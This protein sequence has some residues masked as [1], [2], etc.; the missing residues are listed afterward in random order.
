VR[1]KPHAFAVEEEEYAEENTF[2]FFVFYFY[3]VFR[4]G[5]LI[6]EEDISVREEI[7]EANLG[8]TGGRSEPWGEEES[9]I[10]KGKRKIFVHTHGCGPTRVALV[11]WLP[12]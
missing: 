5:L 11:M 2:F 4:K 9:R 7:V 12:R 6:G 10:E 3:F 1:L 8:K